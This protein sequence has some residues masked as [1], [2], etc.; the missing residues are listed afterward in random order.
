MFSFNDIY[1]DIRRNAMWRHWLPNLPGQRQIKKNEADIV[2][3]PV[4]RK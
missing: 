3:F 4:C 2:G 1:V